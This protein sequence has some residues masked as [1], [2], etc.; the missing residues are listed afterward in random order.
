MAKRGRGHCYADGSKCGVN[1]FSVMDEC[2]IEAREE[3]VIFAVPEK[4]RGGK[5]FAM[6]PDSKTGDIMA[7]YFYSDACRHCSG[8]NEE[9]D[10][11]SKQLN[12]YI[13]RIDIINNPELVESY[14]I[15]GVP[16]FLV[17]RYESDGIKEFT[18]YGKADSTAIINWIAKPAAE[19]QEKPA[20]IEKLKEEILICKDS[21]PLDGKCYP[22][23]YRKGGKY[24]S[25]EGAFKEQLKADAVCD[26]NF[27]CSTN[28]CVDGKCISS[29]FIEKMTNWFKRLFG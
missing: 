25:D 5:K 14:G 16:A 10:K 11:V 19:A 23:G 18:R 12:I 24:C 7:V 2:Y 20:E 3:G 29:G 17:L 9:V 15:K 22:F 8:M 26:N 28:V 4:P 27:E 6:P 21:C 13:K 1:S